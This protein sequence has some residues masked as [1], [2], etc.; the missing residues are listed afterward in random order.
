MFFPQPH[1]A[2]MPVRCQ[3]GASVVLEQGR[4]LPALPQWV[5]RPGD[6]HLLL[7]VLGTQ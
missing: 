7:P 1:G 5:T 4:A 6:N 3:C 2:N